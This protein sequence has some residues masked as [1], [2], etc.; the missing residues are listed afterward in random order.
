VKRLSQTH[1]CRMRQ[2][3]TALGHHIE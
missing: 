3:Q 2:R 1:D